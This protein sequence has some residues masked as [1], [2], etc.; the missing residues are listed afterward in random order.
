[1]RPVNSTA[2]NLAWLLLTHETG[3]HRASIAL[4]D[5][6]ERV[7]DK[8]RLHL[9]K[10]MGLDGFTLLLVRALTFAQSDFPWLEEVQTQQDGSLRGLNTSIETQEPAEAVAG[11]TNLLSHFI[12]LLMNFIGEGLTRHLLQGAWP[13]I[14]LIGK[15]TGSKETT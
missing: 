10:L 1:M 14:D 13:E 9:V 5:A 8:L 15:D 6:M 11:L 12:G 3:E 2:K 7:C 4:A